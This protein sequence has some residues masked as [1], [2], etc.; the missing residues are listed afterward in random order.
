MRT[1][2]NGI[3]TLLLA[4]VVHLTFAQE[5]TVSGTVTDQDGLPLPGVNIV[6]VGTTT[7]TQSDFDG[8]YSIRASAGQT[9]LFSY[10]GQ[11]DVRVDVGASNTINVQ[12]EEDAQALEEVVVTA[13]GI[14]KSKQ[15]LGYAVSEVSNEQLEQR[16]EGDV[17]RI[18]TGKAS[19]V[20]IQN[21]SGLS[22]SG[23]SIIIRGLSTFSGSNQPLFIVDG[24]PFDSGTNQQ[25]DFVDGNTGSSRFLDLDPNNIESVNVLKGLAAATLYGTAGR[26]GVILIT[27]KNGAAG[28]TTK[29]SE[30][31]VTSSM[32]VNNIA[33][34]PDY[35]DEYGNGFDQAFG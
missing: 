28:A 14:K 27:T 25:G 3:L 26:N 34:L 6:V 32:F 30:V 35:Q 5:K 10:I 18:L 17:G 2:L 7:G 21:Q 9:L 16:A 23:T 29:K 24:V 12:M 4:F 11:K 33:S 31:T 15:A 20:N 22:G 1:N 19:G 13:Q 8:N